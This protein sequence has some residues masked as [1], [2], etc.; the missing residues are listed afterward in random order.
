VKRPLPDPINGLGQTSDPSL[1]VT[2]VQVTSRF[3]VVYLTFQDQNV[4]GDGSK[5]SFSADKAHL[6]TADGQR[7]FE[8]VRADG[9]PLAPVYQDVKSGERVEFRLYFDALPADVTEFGLYECE[10]TSDNT[11]WN[12]RHIILPPADAPTAPKQP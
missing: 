11:C 9:I 2:D 7:R 5:I 1:R 3:T 10:S 4:R 6:I 12:V 8:F